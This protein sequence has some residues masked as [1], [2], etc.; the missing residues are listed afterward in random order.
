LHHRALASALGACDHEVMAKKPPAPPP[1]PKPTAKGRAAP[2]PPTTPE[3]RRARKKLDK[4]ERIRDAAWELFTTLGYEPTTTR[5]VAE[6]A[7]VAAG[8]LFLYADDKRD[9]LFLVFHDRLRAATDAARATMPRHGPWLDQM[10]H[11]FRG[12]FRMYGEAPAL[13]AEFVRGLPG[14][15]GRNADEVNALTYATLA[16]LATLTREA[17]GRGEVAADVDPL[18]AARNVFS[19]YFGALLSW[20]MGLAPSVEAAHDPVLKDSLALQLRG[21]APRP[22]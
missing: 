19:L 15:R 14:A 13:S 16:H 2:S 11:M 18:L 22:G 5:A 4:R 12:V 3:E 20:V 21:L 9:L 7:G 1:R 17:K 6:R 8:T 10:M